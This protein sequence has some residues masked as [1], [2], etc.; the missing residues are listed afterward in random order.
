M[1]VC[2]RRSPSLVIPYPGIASLLGNRQEPSG[3]HL[4]MAAN[5][6]ADARYLS[7][8]PHL[9]AV[10]PGV[11]RLQQAGNR[12]CALRPGY[13]QFVYAGRTVRDFFQWPFSEEY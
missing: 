2:S 3:G 7:S 10:D 6:L 5:W 4:G 13:L 12:N 1:L 8:S 9:I 11:G